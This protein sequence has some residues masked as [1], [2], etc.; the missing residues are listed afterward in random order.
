KMPTNFRGAPG[1]IDDP[2]ANEV[3][4]YRDNPSGYGPVA[5]II[6]GAPIP[7]VGGNF[8]A[9]LVGQKVVAATFLVLT[10]LLAGAIARRLGQNPAFVAGLIGLNPLMIW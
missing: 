4:V 6:G 7:F 2:V 5:Y 1:K 8:R 3:R 9:N 10:A